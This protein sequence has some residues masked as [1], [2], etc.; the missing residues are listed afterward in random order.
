MPLIKDN[1]KEMNQQEKNP[2]SLNSAQKEKPSSLLN[3][4]G[5]LL[6]FAPLVYEQFTGQKIPQM[7][8]TLA[9]IQLALSQMQS[10]L[11]ILINNQQGLIQRI[12]NLETNATQQFTNLAHQFQSLRLTHTRE[13]KE[14]DFHPKEPSEEY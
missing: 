7:T 4:I 10:N 8:G 11:Q 2:T 3:T 13:R 9:E 6:P 1:S 5:N 14:I 12:T